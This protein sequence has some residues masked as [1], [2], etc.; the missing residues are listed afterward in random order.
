MKPQF[1]NRSNNELMRAIILQGAAVWFVLVGTSALATVR[2]VDVN[3]AA[4]SL[5]YTTWASAATTIQDAIDVANDGDE[6]VVTNGVYQTGGRAVTGMLTNRVAVTKPVTV[7]SANGA[8]LTVIAGHAGIGDS[9]V[10]C[11]YLTNG[12]VLAGFTLSNGAT[13]LFFNS[14]YQMDVSGGGL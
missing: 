4:P 13:R 11:V 3:G 14:N 8:G 1:I 10:R 12:A 9:A 2:Y 6:V 5:P 7:R